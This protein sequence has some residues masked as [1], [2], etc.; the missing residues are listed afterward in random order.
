LQ[1]APVLRPLSVGDIVDRVLRLLRADA[2]LFIGIA[3]LPNLIV[4]ILQRVAGVSQTFDLNDLG[5]AIG[6]AG[7]PVVPRQLQPANPGAAVAVVIVGLALS[8]LQAC[9]LMEAIGQ[10]YLGRP[11]TIREAYRRGLRAV[12]RLI[13]SGLAVVAVFGAV[14]V[15]VIIALA[16]LG[17]SPAAAV[18]IVIGLVVFVVVLPWGALSLAVVGP[19]IVLE[20]LGPIAAIRRS[21]HLMDRSRLRTLGLYILIGILS[22]LA[23]IVF[24]I[25]F[26]ASFVSEP[27]VR[28]VLQTIANVASAAVSGPLVYGALVVLYYDL[29]VRKEAYDLQLAA[30]ALPRE[31]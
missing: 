10:R 21:F 11:I 6:T 16:A 19:A 29:R 13:L 23:G 12:P 20:G 4:E 7:G 1:D 2:V 27:T 26:L 24:G 5:T 8:L 28:A 3:V 17:G 9:A 30:E 14:L 18:A 22:T 31:A 15:L 25:V